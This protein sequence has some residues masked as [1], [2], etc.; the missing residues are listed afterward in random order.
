[1]LISVHDLALAGRLREG[2]HRAG[3]DV[4]LLVAT[5]DP[6][7]FPKAALLILTGGLE[8]PDRPKILQRAAQRGIPAIGVMAGRGPGD[9]PA[10][11]SLSAVFSHSADPQEVVMAGLG[12][13]DRAQLRAETGIIGETPVMVQVLDKIRQFAAVQATVL[14]T[15][16]SGTGKELVARGIH[17]LSG[18]RDRSFIPVNMGALS[19]T[20]LESEL[21]GHEKGAFTGAVDRRK[22]VFELAHGGT[23][24]MD[25]IGEM[26]TS[27]QVKL[28]RV[29][30]QGDFLRVGGQE[31]ISV[32][33]RVVAAS[34]RW[35][36]TQVER[37]VFRADLFYR[38]NV[39]RIH[40]PPL[41]ERRADI[42]LLV[43]HFIR[44]AC[45]RHDRQFAGIS[46]KAMEILM[47]R[48][49]PGNVREL[50]NLVESMVVLN[51]GSV[52]RARDLPRERMVRPPGGGGALQPIEGEERETGGSELAT[53]LSF[54]L[55]TLWRM[56]LDIE[57]LRGDF[58]KFTGET[59]GLA[60]GGEGEIPLLPSAVGRAKAAPSESIQVDEEQAER[61]PRARMEERAAQGLAALRSGMSLADVER[62][63]VRLAL[64][65]SS[66]NRRKAA[67]MLGIGTRTVY[68]K[69]RKYGLEED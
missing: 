31:P 22:G 23:I 41:T 40:V 18:R 48:A 47:R 37:G 25:E 12:M 61:S 2:F 58:R 36:E 7:R 16:E 20:L 51:P 69:I 39:L 17:V 59:E 32:D 33:A 54:I 67:E 56:K 34:N 13:I 63:L 50:K 65:E 52:V 44:D 42:P 62:E 11:P 29:L 64:K 15:G 30:E 6:S 21:F 14:V 66:G 35:L 5:D 19:E 57:S 45:E 3:K 46:P 38:L 60:G 49:W 28:L 43:D 26:P 68:R 24:F 1:M 53:Q 4:E 27:T 55:H 10:L 9:L 8:G